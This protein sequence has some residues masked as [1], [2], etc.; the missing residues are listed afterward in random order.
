MQLM[1]LTNDPEF[2]LEAE[3]AG[4]NRIF[5]DLEYLNKAE[6]QR[7]LNTVISN[8]SLEDIKV[9]KS[10]ITEANL[11]V[12]V[13]PINPMSEK[14]ID[15]AIDN[16][17][18]IIMLPMAF[19]ANDASDF[20]RFVNGRAKTIVMIETAAA[21]ARIDDFI[22]IK[23]VDEFFIGLNDLKIDLGLNFMFEV[24]SGGLVEYLVNKIHNAGSVVGFGGIAK[25]GEG[26][27]PAELILSEHVRL[28]SQSVILSRTFKN[29][30]AVSNN[31]GKIN[32]DLEVF[33]LR[34]KYAELK[35]KSKSDLDKNKIDIINIVRKISGR[36]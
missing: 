30:P 8:H 36:T 32:L 3:S 22:D 6:R 5:I 20:I 19:D 18:D 27:L 33:K 7:G 31:E 11:L 10:V 16:G 21:L 1:I 26:E 9:I 15:T 29:D 4:I 17:A 2:A 35:S 25:L 28:G 13:N 23:G 12:R 24:L 34:S 14:E